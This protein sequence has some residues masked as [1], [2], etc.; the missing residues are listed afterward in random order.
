MDTAAQQLTG[1]GAHVISRSTSVLPCT[2]QRG[3]TLQAGQRT[4]S[5][6]CPASIWHGGTGST[7]VLTV[8]SGQPVTS[9]DKMLSVSSAVIEAAKNFLKKKGNNFPKSQGETCA[10][11]PQPQNHHLLLDRGSSGPKQCTWPRHPLMQ[12]L[13]QPR[14]KDYC[15][16]RR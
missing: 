4:S 15:H 3:W 1:P 2:Q 11:L 10:D 7:T 9:L 13:V 14:N 6:H 16:H 8:S 12:G 5:T